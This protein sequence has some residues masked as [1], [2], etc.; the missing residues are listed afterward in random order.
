MTL[1]FKELKLTEDTVFNE[2]IEVEANISGY[3]NLSVNG[4]ITAR[5]ITARDIN[6]WNIKSWGIILCE[7]VKVKQKIKAKAV[8]RKRSELKI[9]EWK[10]D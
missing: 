9:K 4:D 6:A 5:D 3:Y 10:S 8:I 7:S 2:S 1:K